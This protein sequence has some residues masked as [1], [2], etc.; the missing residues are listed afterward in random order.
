MLIRL[1]LRVMANRPAPLSLVVVTALVAGAVAV[2]REDATV[3]VVG[4]MGL[5]ACVGH[6]GLIYDIL[7]RPRLRRLRAVL[8]VSRAEVLDAWWLA[9]GAALVLSTVLAMVIVSLTR[10]STALPVPVLAVLFAAAIAPC[11]PLA[12]RFDG[13][14]L[15]WTGAPL[16]VAGLAAGFL[17]GTLADVGPTLLVIIVGVG[18]AIVVASWWLSHRVYRVQD[19]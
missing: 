11:V 7:E 15:V 17:A 19:H 13:S 4:I 18:L 9:A 2:S 16:F 1:D 5:G 12:L 14:G 6:M 8:P 3:S 10:A